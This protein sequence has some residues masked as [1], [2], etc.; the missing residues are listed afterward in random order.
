MNLLKQR[1]I[2]CPLEFHSL[3]FIECQLYAK[4][5]AK[6]QG[7]KYDSCAQQK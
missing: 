1:Q 7:Y 6:A 4:Y 3:P 2:C 5:G